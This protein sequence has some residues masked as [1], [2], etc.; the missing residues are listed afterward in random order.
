MAVKVNAMKTQHE[1]VSHLQAKNEQMKGES[2][3]KERELIEQMQQLERQL[4][5]E[6]TAHAE[7][8]NGRAPTALPPPPAE[9]APVGDSTAM[10]LEARLQ[11]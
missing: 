4:D 3:A 11:V 6:R 9:T 10:K 5:A 2:L 8:R 1:L 7:T